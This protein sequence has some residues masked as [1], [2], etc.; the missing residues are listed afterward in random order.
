MTVGELI[1]PYWHFKVTMIRSGMPFRLMPDASS[2]C[3]KILSSNAR[4]VK[5]TANPHGTTANR[6]TITPPTVA[7]AEP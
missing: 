3:H 1:P 7:L 2:Q 5:T 4:C 6:P